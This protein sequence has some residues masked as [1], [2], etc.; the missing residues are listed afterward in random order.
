MSDLNMPLRALGT[1]LVPQPIEEQVET[2]PDAI[3]L[4][5][6][7]STLTYAELNRRAN[8]LAH[9]LQ[10]L[11]VGP[12]KLV[13]LC[14]E[15][16]PE[17]VVAAL[18]VF[19]AGGAYVPLDPAAPAERTEM[20]LR[21]ADVCALVTKSGL[22]KTSLNGLL[23]SA[24][25]QVVN[26]EDDAA[27]IARRPEHAPVVSLTPENLAYVIYTS[28][29]TGQPKGV[30]VTQGN[31]SNLLRWH[32]QAFEVTAEDRASHQAA[33]GFDAA[34]WEVWP[35]LAAGASVHFPEDGVR[36]NPAALRDWIVAQ[37][38]TITFLA[39][40][41]AES[42]LLLDWPREVDLRILL[43]G[44]DTLH[45]RPSARLPFVLVNN[46]GPTECTVVA[47]SGVVASAESNTRPPSIGRAI[48]N[49]E[50]F[51]LDDQM[52]PVTPGNAGELYIGG[53]SVARGY[54]NRPELTAERFVADPMRPNSS[55]RLY[56]TGDLVR[57]LPG[58]EIEFLGRI[59]EQIKIRGYRI[60][61]S[62]IVSALDASADIDASAVMA[63]ENGAG[64]KQLV[65]YVVLADGAE[66]TAGGLQ[67]L[68]RRQLPDY[69]IPATFVRIDSLPVTNNGK[70]DWSALP[71][72][73]N[74]N[75]LADDSYVAPRNIVEEKL[76]GIIAPLLHVERVGVH[77][78]FFF[79][80]GHSL[81]GTQLITKISETFGVEL[82]LLNLFE[83]PTLA[84]M[85]EEIEH[86][87]FSK[88]E[89]EKIE[90][91]KNQAAKIEEAE[92]Q[93]RQ[94]LTPAQM[95]REDVA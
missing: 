45:R 22:A 5:S 54:R 36:N 91:G 85:S 69:M 81:L 59:D 35:Y 50:I 73:L 88:I 63:R 65:A 13:A 15:R 7:S 42:M 27:E 3:A 4:A 57:E 46:Y 31:L 41:L 90:A 10:T 23:A 37:R 84:E 11:G 58:G 9:H 33:L 78:N 80:G 32:L 71:L 83:H 52:E 44:A 21:D 48:E 95:R 87:I 82:S 61:P 55:G 77:D 53:A 60:E 6:G 74:G 1:G 39:T 72:P 51:I 18:A 79:R 93:A 16:S 12:E 38:I 66:T 2:R 68:L 8:Q 75:V 19:K 43:T 86:L 20:M 62:E 34:V 47:T 25:F 24:S 56:R 14:L 40:P 29:S 70:V 64:E 67:E 49:T 17:M 30:E 76:A 28:G 26:L 94:D 92:A 89:T